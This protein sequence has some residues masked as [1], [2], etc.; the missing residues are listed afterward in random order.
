MSQR[1]D[2]SQC[3]GVVVEFES[4]DVRHARAK[5]ARSIPGELNF[6]SNENFCN[7]S[8]AFAL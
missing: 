7:V 4:D 1:A 5:K 3:G 6:K 2:A 8:V